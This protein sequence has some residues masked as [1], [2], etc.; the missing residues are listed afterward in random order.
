MRHS[1]TENLLREGWH[2]GYDIRPTKRQKGYGKKILALAL[3]K[4]KEKGLTK[5]LI[6][7]TETNTESKKLSRQMKECWKIVLKWG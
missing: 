3:P 2:I 5:V 1:S 4:A 6:T 7:C